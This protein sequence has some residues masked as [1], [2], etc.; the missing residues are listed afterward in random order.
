MAETSAAEAGSAADRDE[1]AVN[2][3][4]GPPSTSAAAMDDLLPG[5]DDLLYEEELLRNPYSLKMW[6]R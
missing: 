6:C 3:A 2:G 5:E 1:T 4:A